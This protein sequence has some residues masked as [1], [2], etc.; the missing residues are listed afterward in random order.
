MFIDKKGQN[1]I[2]AGSVGIFISVILVSF[3]TRNISISTTYYIPISSPTDLLIGLGFLLALIPPALV[4]HIN[5]VHTNAVGKNI[6]KFL[7][8]ILQSTDSGMTLP[9]SLVEASKS[10]YG[11]ISKELGI[12]M[13]KFSM[14]YDFK[15][16]L[17]AA[18]RRLHHQRAPQLSMILSEAYAAGGKIH[19]VLTTSSGL[20]ATLEEYQEDRQTQLRPYTMLVYIS[21][22]VYFIVVFIAMG[23]FLNQV[24]KLVG[25]MTTG[26]NFLQKPPPLS[27]YASIFFW[28]GIFESIFGGLVAGKISDNSALTG[29]KHSVILTG[30]TLAFFWLLIFPGA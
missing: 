8:D 14:G 27:Y 20:Y 13:T 18:A 22:A 16:S 28:T 29:L 25:S 11:P 30:V 23:E 17:E 6:P 19:D 3:L 26:S 15:E 5:S 9:A 10:D 21:L 12:A 4:G 7:A 2:L 24:T 1:I